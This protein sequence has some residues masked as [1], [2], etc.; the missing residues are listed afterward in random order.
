MWGEGVQVSGRGGSVFLG[1][2]FIVLLRDKN[3]AI[4]VRRPKMG[5]L[6]MTKNGGARDD[7][8]WRI[9]HQIKA[10]KDIVG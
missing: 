5:E 6:E 10:F 9:K 4:Q 8:S 7:S 3:M 1:P 2:L